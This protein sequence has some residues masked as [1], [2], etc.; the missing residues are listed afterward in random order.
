VHMAVQPIFAAPRFEF[1]ASA[2][3]FAIGP[4][5]P[6]P[7]IDPLEEWQKQPKPLYRLSWMHRTNTR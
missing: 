4:S 7:M 6:S 3:P 5:L 2:A 1:G